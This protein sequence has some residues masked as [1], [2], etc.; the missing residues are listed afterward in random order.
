MT[1]LVVP[2]YVTARAGAAFRI[3]ILGRPYLAHPHED[4][5]PGYALTPDRLQRFTDRAVR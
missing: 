1:R 2:A 3:R 4:G 5:R